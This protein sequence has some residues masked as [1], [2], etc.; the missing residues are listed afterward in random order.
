VTSLVKTVKKLEGFN[1]GAAP[2]FHFNPF[3]FSTHQVPNPMF[4]LTKDEKRVVA[5]L[6]AVLLIGM[7]VRYWRE[8]RETSRTPP[9]GAE[10]EQ[11]TQT[12]NK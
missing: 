5:F 4:K 11:L 1:K 3:N 10:Q 9:D 7:A 6:V 8:S 12:R 2:D